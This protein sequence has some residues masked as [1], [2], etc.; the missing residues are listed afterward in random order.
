MDKVVIINNGDGTCGI[1]VPA[2]DMFVAGSK[3]RSLVPELDNSTD[4]E[5]LDWIIAKD[6]PDGREHRI[7]DR[8]NLPV[9]RYFRNA[10]TDDNNTDTVD[11]DMEKARNIQ[12][13]NIRKVRNEKLQALDIA[14]MKA[15]SLGDS[16]QATDIESQKQVLRDIPQTFD[17]SVYETPEDLKEA[18][19]E[20]LQN[21]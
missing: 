15:L 8:A 21:V 10:W 17:L 13:T 12:M 4:V 7:V 20:E 1:I 6:V 16:E 9:D 3:T 2:P 18:M 5:V 14:T 19:P 11:V